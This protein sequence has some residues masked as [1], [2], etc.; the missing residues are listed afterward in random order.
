MLKR[1]LVFDSFFWLNTILLD[2]YTTLGLTIHSLIDVWVVLTSAAMS[3]Y[4]CTL[5]NFHAYVLCRGISLRD[6]NL[7]T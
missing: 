1:A 7:T 4:V 5:L 2:A 3:I 6:S